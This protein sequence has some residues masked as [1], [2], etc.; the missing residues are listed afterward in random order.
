MNECELTLAISTL[1]E[2]HVPP[3]E[4]YYDEFDEI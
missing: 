3:E 4:D 1:G 2:E